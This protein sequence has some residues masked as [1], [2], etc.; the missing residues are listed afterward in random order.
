MSCKEERLT[1]MLLLVKVAWRKGSDMKDIVK[2][3]LYP[4]DCIAR[5]VCELAADISRDYRGREVLIVCVLKGAFVFLA[6]LA[7]CLEI[8]YSIDFIRLASYGS[9]MASSGTIT[10]T[11]D[12][13][14]PIEGKDILVVEDIVD[15]GLTMA[16]L[17]ERLLKSN[18]NSVKICALI[19]KKQRRQ[20][21][22]DVDYVGFHMD[23][24]FIV[25]YGLDY[26]EQLRCLPDIYVIEE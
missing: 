13:E 24:G 14:T 15:S 19:D 3:I 9:E 25:G 22:M 8:P 4:R 2:K 1:G 26:D 11:K 17:M 10:V 6:D 23:E 16:F 21:A 7:R 20:V 18:P 5:R 12:I